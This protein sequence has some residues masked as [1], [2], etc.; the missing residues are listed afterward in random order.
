MKNPLVVL[1]ISAIATFAM[2]WFGHRVFI[3]STTPKTEPVQKAEPVKKNDSPAS[4]APDTLFAKKNDSSSFKPE[5]IESDTDKPTVILAS[6]TTDTLWRDEKEI[7]LK[8][9]D[10][11]VDIRR[12]FILKKTFN[13]YIVN[14]RFNGKFPKKLNYSTAKY[15]RLHKAATHRAVEKK[16]LFAGRYAFAV[17]ECGVDCFTSTLV[18]LKTGNVY[19]GPHAS[20]GYKFEAN[21]RMLIVNPVAPDGFYTP[22]EFC[23]PE[24]YVWTGKEFKRVQ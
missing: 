24:V 21:S 22:C 2:G 23:E 18:D 17:I 12:K 1:A 14:E 6:A 13:D 10:G 5:K 11:S 19:D 9:P 7:V 3:K 4:P 16:V 20:T 8:H 15:A